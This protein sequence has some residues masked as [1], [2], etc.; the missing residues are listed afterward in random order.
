MPE[1][2]QTPKQYDHRLRR[3]IQT[4]GDLDLAVRYGVP[5]STARGLLKQSRADVVFREG[6]DTDAKALPQEALVLRGRVTRLLAFL[7]LVVVAIRVAAFSFDKVRILNGT[8]KRELLWAI[9][10]V[11]TQRNRPPSPLIRPL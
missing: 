5:C 8:R 3:P 9:E 11:R 4:T 7:Q 10:R 2:T 1:N 6:L